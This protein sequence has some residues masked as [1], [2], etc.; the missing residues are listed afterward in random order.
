MTPPPSLQQL[1][2]TVQQDSP[3]D[4]SLDLLITASTT[5]GQL[6]AVNDALLEH[7]V[8][9]CRRAGRSWSEIST[10]LGVSKQAVHK[11]FSGPIAD[12]LIQAQR[13]RPSL[14]RFTTRARS[15]LAAAAA[16]A[17]ARHAD[18][19]GAEDLLLGL[20]A[21]PE[22][23]AAKV[24]TAMNV[25]QG[26]VEA[27]RPGSAAAG[28]SQ[29]AEP[30]RPRPPYSPEA[31]ATLRD[32]LVEALELG[33]NYIGTEHILL[34]LLRDSDAPAARI[35]NQLGVSPAETK[36]RIGELLKGFTGK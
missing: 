25:T 32:A 35:L 8:D 12:R 34:G 31:V 4:E 15:V 13:D 22:G 17:K 36:V 3:T 19:V 20:F 14:E 2:D 24:L 26:S 1:I 28:G 23:V 16:A 7:Y 27:I 5:V 30:E 18:H 11:R 33:H 29:P 9:R 21:E 10:A 6:E